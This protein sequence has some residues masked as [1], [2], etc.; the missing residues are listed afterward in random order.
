M[1]TRGKYIVIE[2][3]DGTGKST[4]VK[5]LTE[6]LNQSGQPAIMIEEPGSDDPELTTPVAAYLRQVIKNAN[7]E[8]APEIDVALFS[9]ARRELLQQKIIPNLAKGVFV[10]SARNYLSTLAYQGGGDG[11]SAEE[12]ADTT[13]L[14]TDETYMNPDIMVVLTLDDTSE[15]LRR[16]DG[17]GE[18]ENPD[19]FESKGDDFQ[20]KVDQAYLS[21]AEQYDIPVI[22]ATQTVDAVYQ[23]LLKLLD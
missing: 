9:A 8:R 14:F 1:E 15:R 21:L 23:D 13:R 12:I 7:L 5:R 3:H 17:R 22:D 4:Q 6:Y 11:V 16:I 20:T 18:L 19:T 10:L 2:G